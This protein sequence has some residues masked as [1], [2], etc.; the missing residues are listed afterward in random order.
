MLRSIIALSTAP[1]LYCYVNAVV[2]KDYKLTGKHYLHCLP[3]I[4]ACLILV[5]NFFS[6]GA[7]EKQA[8][9]DNMNN[10]P[11]TLFILC[12]VYIQV[13]SYI[14]VIFRILNRQ[15][16]VI[17]ENYSDEHHLTNRW[18]IQ[19][20]SIF[21]FCYLLALTRTLYTFSA[22]RNI[23]TILTL[24]MMFSI[25]LS[26]CW[27]LWQALNHPQLFIGINSRIEVLSDTLNIEEH[28]NNPKNNATTK[29]DLIEKLENHMLI[30]KP[31]WIL[32]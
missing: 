12:L 24:V 18:L 3:F 19:F 31:F 26:I 20:I 13:G 30:N 5:P 29:D 11:E 8:F 6:V 23:E 22:Y 25:F 15:R 28:A 17:I 4:L 2:Y 21:S 7:E 10:M 27:I 14:V 32:F 16:K 1:F 9:Y